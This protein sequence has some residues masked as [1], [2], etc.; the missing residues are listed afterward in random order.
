[1]HA[2][3]ARRSFAPEADAPEADTQRGGALGALQ[4]G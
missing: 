1:M 3:R 4:K 2:I